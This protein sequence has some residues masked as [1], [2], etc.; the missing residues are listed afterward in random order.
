MLSVGAAATLRERQ[1]RFA[2]G[3]EFHSLIQQAL[4]VYNESIKS[5]LRRFSDVD[6]QV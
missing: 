4:S 5:N 3:A 1:R 6:S 2:F